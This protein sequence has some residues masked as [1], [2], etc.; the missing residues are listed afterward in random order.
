MMMEEGFS[1][2]C[3][4]WLSQ[5]PLGLS[6]NDFHERVAMDSLLA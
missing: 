5:S 3:A 1:T 6:C 2:S 4:V